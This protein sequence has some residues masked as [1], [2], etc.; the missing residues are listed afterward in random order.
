MQSHLWKSCKNASYTLTGITLH[1]NCFDIQHPCKLGKALVLRNGG[2]IIKPLFDAGLRF[3]A[4]TCSVD[5]ILIK[6]GIC[7]EKED[8]EFWGMERV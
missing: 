7:A 8:S 6:V 4:V 1:N 5:Q 3:G 2:H